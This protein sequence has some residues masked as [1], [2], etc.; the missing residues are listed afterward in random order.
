MYPTWEHS[1]FMSMNRVERL[2]SQWKF[3]SLDQQ[4]MEPFFF[5]D[6]NSE[7]KFA[8]TQKM[9]HD[10]HEPMAF[11]ARFIIEIRD[12]LSDSQD[13]H[14]LN[15]MIQFLIKWNAKMVIGHFFSLEFL[16]FITILPWF[17]RYSRMKRQTNARWL[18][19]QTM[20]L[21]LWNK[22]NRSWLWNMFILFLQSWS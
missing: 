9:H 7:V 12:I 5:A 14:I 11:I 2:T 18:H 16:R 15:R 3:P 8:F 21:L 20:L 6:F 22:W 17:K 13:F 1:I 4:K 19:K 10:R